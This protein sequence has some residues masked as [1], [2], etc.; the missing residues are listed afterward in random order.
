MK[1]DLKPLDP[2]TENMGFMT[3]KPTKAFI[4]Q[5][6]EAHMAVHMALARSKDCMQCWVKTPWDS[7]YRRCSGAHHGAYGVPVPSRDREATGC[8]A[9]RPCQKA[10]RK[11][12]TTSS[13]RNRSP[14]SQ[15]AAAAA[16]RVL[17][18]DQAEMQMQQSLSRCKIRLVQ[19][20]QMDLQIKQMQAQTKQMQ[21]Q[22][23]SSTQDGRTAAQTSRRMSWTPPPK[24]MNLNLRE[25]R[26][27]WSAAA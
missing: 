11:A 15:V 7:N 13:A 3:G 22:M 18:K 10:T 12:S 19:M 23:D 4:Y 27:L 21:V 8:F 20:Q 14:T 1:D 2:V 17:Q 6:H 26:Y 25:G 16:A 24:K 5:D 9:C